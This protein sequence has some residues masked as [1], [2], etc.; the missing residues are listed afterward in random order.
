MYINAS[1]PLH[2][3]ICWYLWTGEQTFAFSSNRY[4]LDLT[5]EAMS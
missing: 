2:H 5:E 1:A 3:I 4:L